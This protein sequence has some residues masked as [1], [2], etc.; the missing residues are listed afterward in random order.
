M[1]VMICSGRSHYKE[2]LGNVV[3]SWPQRINATV[4]PPKRRP[5]GYSNWFALNHWYLNPLTVATKYRRRGKVWPTR[6]GRAALRGWT[7]GCRLKLINQA[8]FFV[9]FY[10]FFI[11]IN[12]E[13]EFSVSSVTGLDNSCDELDVVPK[14]FVHFLTCVMYLHPHLHNLHQ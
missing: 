3:V 5:L 10:S 7:S 8:V 1:I 14:A 13:H 12:T 2:R 11:N 4:N 9:L 6:Q